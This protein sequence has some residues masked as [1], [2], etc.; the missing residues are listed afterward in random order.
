[1][2]QTPQV[3]ALNLYRAAAYVARDEG[4]TV[5]DDNQ[6]LEHIRVPVKMVACNRENIK[7]TEPA[8]VIF[9]TAILEARKKAA[10]EAEGAQ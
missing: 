7:I 5:S 10:A 6:M 1:M 3:F 9:A 2:A 8:D 4:L